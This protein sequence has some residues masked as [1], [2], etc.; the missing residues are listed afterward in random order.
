MELS[1]LAYEL[2]CIVGLVVYYLGQ[3]ITF[4]RTHIYTEKILKGSFLAETNS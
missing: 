1:A 2:K 3:Q 4:H